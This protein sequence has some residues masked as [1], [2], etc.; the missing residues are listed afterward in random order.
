M[1]GWAGSSRRRRGRRCRG[2]RSGAD[3]HVAVGCIDR[4]DHLARPVRFRFGSWARGGV[5][6]GLIG[7]GRVV[8]RHWVE[9]TGAEVRAEIRICGPAALRI[10]A[11]RRRTVAD[12]PPR[13]CWQTVVR[14]LAGRCLPA[15]TAR[16]L[17]EADVVEL[18]GLAEAMDALESGLVRFAR[19]EA[20][21]LDETHISFGSERDSS[22]HA[23]GAVFDARAEEFDADA[24]LA[25]TKT[26]AHTP[27]GAS[28]VMVVWD[29]T[30]GELLAIIEAY[31]LG[32]LRA[33]AMTGVATRYLAP[34]EVREAALI[35]TGTQA[36][37][38]AAAMCAARPIEQLRVHSPNPEH[39]RSFAERLANAGIEVRVV[40]CETVAAATDGVSLLTLVTRA[41]EPF[42]HAP[43]V[44][45]VAHVNAIGAITP[46]QAEVAPDLV[47]ACDL[48]AADLPDVAR[49]LAARELGA[50]DDVVAIADLVAARQHRP[51]GAELTLFKATGMGVCDLALAADVL[52]RA[53]R[54]GLGQPIPAPETLA[55]RLHIDASPEGPTT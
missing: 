36:I 14:A 24:G 35:G 7:L 54:E 37:P 8:S 50:V 33:A 3:H 31:A 32:Q 21:N 25:G 1:R 41:T 47:A 48:V 34:A 51:V 2:R 18:V 40:E 39:R 49:R 10:G 43:M 22:L 16:W 19:S 9:A 4:R 26:W 29:A 38:Q 42:L 15:V 27:A 23:L 17:R 20:R 13:S 53:R 30:T 12:P 44:A 52:D 5:G 46:T 45:P 6:E 28:P 11:D 55:P